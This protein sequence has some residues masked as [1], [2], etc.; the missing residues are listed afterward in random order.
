MTLR[1]GVKFSDGET[2]TADDVAFTF[3]LTRRYPALDEHGMWRYL[4]RV[5][6]TDQHQIT[7]SFQDPYTLDL[8]YLPTKQSSPIVIM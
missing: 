4:E 1:P 2:L 7:F 6:A 8:F 3:D 5:D